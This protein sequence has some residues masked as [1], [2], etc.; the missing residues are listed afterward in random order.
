[1]P[2]VAANIHADY[3]GMGSALASRGAGYLAANILGVILQNIVK[4]HSDGILICAFILP[5][6]VV[7]VTPFVGS[8][9]LLCILFF[10]QGAAQ[11]FTDL[12]KSIIFKML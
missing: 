11:G 3:S 12:G 8:L 5:A 1:M 7:F 10:V 6:I 2:V 9:I 4:K